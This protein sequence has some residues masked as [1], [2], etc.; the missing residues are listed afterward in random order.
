MS[1]LLLKQLHQLL[2]PWDSLPD[3]ASQDEGSEPA[4]SLWTTPPPA[5]PN[6][7]SPCSAF[8][9]PPP[10]API[11]KRTSAGRLADESAAA[12][13]AYSR[14]ATTKLELARAALA[15]F[16][17]NAG[18]YRPFL[19]KLL[20]FLFD[21]VDELRQEQGRLR[22]EQWTWQQCGG[23][24]TAK[25]AHESGRGF[26]GA[27][28]EEQ[29]AVAA[30]YEKVR[31]TEARMAALVEEAA[32]QRDHFKSQMDMQKSYQYHLEDLLRHQMELTQ[33]L[34][35]HH[36]HQDLLTGKQSAAVTMAT[37]ASHSLH[38]D[39][40]LDG[41][42]HGDHG[43]G[44]FR[45]LNLAT[46]P[47]IVTRDILGL[48]SSHAP[49]RTAERRDAAYV[50]SLISRA[51]RE[52]LL[53]RT[54]D[55]LRDLRAQHDTLQS[56]LQSL[57]KLN[58]RYACQ[59]VEL[60]ARL[61]VVHEHNIALAADAQLF[62]RDFVR[63]R[64][65]VE[66]LQRELLVARGAVR[67]M[68]QVGLGR[69]PGLGEEA[70]DQPDASKEGYIESWRAGVAGNSGDAGMRYAF[71]TAAPPTP[72]AATRVSGPEEAAPK[73]SCSGERGEG[74]QKKLDAEDHIQEILQLVPDKGLRNQLQELLTIVDPQYTGIKAS[75]LQILQLSCGTNLQ[76]GGSGKNDSLSLSSSG[77]QGWLSRAS[78]PQWVPP[79][80]VRPDV[81]L[82]LRSR[83]SVPFL[84]LHPVVAEVF[85]H[86]MLSQRQELLWFSQ[87]QL[88]ERQTRLR[89]ADGRALDRRDSRKASVTTTA[90]ASTTMS[91]SFQ[92]YIGLFVLVVWLN[93]FNDFA[94]LLPAAMREKAVEA[95]RARLGSGNGL[96]GSMAAPG[97]SATDADG[98][99]Q[100]RDKGTAL[101]SLWDLRYVMPTMRLAG[102][103]EQ[104][105]VEGLQL[106]YALD[107]ASTQLSAG[108]LT[109]AYGLTSRGTVCDVLFELLQAERSV[110]V[111]LCRAVE[112]DM[113][114]RVQDR[115]LGAGAR[116]QGGRTQV[117]R[118]K[119]PQLRG[120]NSATAAPTSP[121]GLRPSTSLRGCIPVVQVARVLLT[122]Y[123]GYSA[124]IMEQLLR[125]AV[126]E[127]TNATENPTI[128]F[129]EV[130]LPSRM[131]PGPATASMS[132]DP[133]M[134]VGTSFASVFYTAICDDVLESMQIVEDS[135]CGFARGHQQS[136]GVSALPSSSAT[137]ATSGAATA[138]AQQLLSLAFLGV[139]RPES[140]CWG[141]FLRSAIYR[142]PRLR[143][144]VA[145][146]PLA[147]LHTS[148]DGAPLEGGADTTGEGLAIREDEM[149]AVAVASGPSGRPSLAS[150]VAPA[151]LTSSPL[152]TRNFFS[153]EDTRAAAGVSPTARVSVKEVVP[154]LRQHL[155]IRR[156]PYGWAADTAAT[157]AVDIS[158]LLTEEGDR[159]APESPRGAQATAAKG[160]WATG[161][162]EA[163][164]QW[165]AAYRGLQHW[166][167][168]WAHYSNATATSPSPFEGPTEPAE[169]Q[170]MLYQTDPHRT[171]A[172]G[173]ELLS[174]ENPLM[175]PVTYAWVQ[176]NPV[177]LE[178]STRE[179]VG[180]G[181]ERAAGRSKKPEKGRRQSTRGR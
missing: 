114:A 19:V 4:S 90:A 65:R 30:A 167:A 104:L 150:G 168:Q 161:A 35:D 123:P 54:E 36:L 140:Q 75:L 141:P 132:I 40:G 119:G 9:S 135:V 92:E 66:R 100:P 91:M 113:L 97:V 57:L 89:A 48:E 166:G 39:R 82:Q 147:A 94:R 96:A 155:L 68:L 106:T 78:V 118:S 47:A 103:M 126:A 127:G 136:S 172:W 20:R 125:T 130:L 1:E 12:C 8:S 63:E 151:A 11:A 73:L 84:L 52:L 180:K 67:S 177:V 29:N 164:Q 108:P 152:P 116:R 134:A 10:L 111:E 33:V 173:S 133:S 156:G 159:V 18:V 17:S 71:E 128:L 102:D 26:V 56:K 15:L 163:A 143:A 107:R 13:V 137:V 165:P 32:V 59:S 129:Y 81:P 70:N 142:W 45:G 28:P 58:S 37:A 86:E 72:E 43:H 44:T 25:A 24:S 145:D 122:M 171:C 157:P 176:H 61:S 7:T 55:Q 169:F 158:P 170:Q 181:G 42:Y 153:V 146:G 83:S 16:A 79:H 6:R 120:A 105:P 115:E 99:P 76:G 69:L 87:R 34:L 88:E 93:R 178:P 110:F 53:E 60:S 174:H 160:K 148:A 117:A 41:S 131:L 154:Y 179:E 144:S 109:Y 46:N 49:M 112:A 14:T 85:V 74:V 162:E 80:G 175:H 50:Q 124:T 21:H 5:A 2:T 31:M 23:A 101:V 3:K 51:E 38:G 22:M 139:P 98:A 95:A 138:T 62:Q 121:T 64:Q 77:V 149:T 27:T